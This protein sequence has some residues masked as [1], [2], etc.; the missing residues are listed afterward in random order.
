MAISKPEM[1][2]MNLGRDTVHDD[3][4]LYDIRSTWR[5]IKRPR[6]S[7]HVANSGPATNNRQCFIT[8][9]Y[10]PDEWSG[11]SALARCYHAEY[12]CIEVSALLGAPSKIQL[13]RT[14]DDYGKSS[15]WWNQHEG[16][17]QYSVQ[18]GRLCIKATGNNVMDGQETDMTTTINCYACVLPCP[19]KKENKI[20]A[21]DHTPDPM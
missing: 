18:V 21:S 12:L 4:R 7:S 13:H 8:S 9:S 17:K 16:Y 10:Q 2:T 15:W 1:T 11:R 14:D 3:D 19:S 6:H 20:T 5:A